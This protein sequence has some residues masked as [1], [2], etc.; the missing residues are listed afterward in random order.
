V[1]RLLAD[2]RTRPAVT[3][4]EVAT[5][6]P[7]SGSGSSLHFN[8]AGR[9]P[10]GPEEF[11]I[12]GYRAVTSGYFSAL[13]IPLLAGRA[14]NDRDRDGSPAVAVV[15]ETFV[16]RFFA[17]ARERALGAHIQIGGQPND[18][19]P[20]MEV[21]GVVGDTRQDLQAE[22]QPIAYVPYL[23]PTLS[24]LEG[25]YRNPVVLLRSDGNPAVLAGSL[26]AAVHD[27]D[28][29]QGLARVRTMENAMSESVSAPRLRTTLLALFSGLALVLSL[30]GVYG[31]MAYAVSERTHEIGVRI[32]LGA[33]SGDIRSLVVGAGLKLAGAGIGIGLVSAVATSRFI[34]TLLFGI[35]PLDPSTFVL[36]AACLSVAA[37]AAAYGPARRASRIAAVGLLR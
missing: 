11:V 27:I 6:P 25:M 23:Q 35:D 5:A 26:R 17:G 14:F 13:R 8:I 15:N 18:E 10:K 3:M 16:K 34:Q 9:P 21:V 32:A 24:I 28:P 12:T 19:A 20:L 29:N 22:A 7:F 1:E 36:A 2:L 33:S 37:I 30:V 4:A 31:V